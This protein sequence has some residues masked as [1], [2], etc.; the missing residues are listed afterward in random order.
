MT[1]IPLL[2]GEKNLEQW[3]LILR[4][5]LKDYQLCQLS[6][7]N[8]KVRAKN[9]NGRMLGDRIR[10]ILKKTVKRLLDQLLQ[11]QVRTLVDMVIFMARNTGQGTLQKTKLF[12]LMQF[13]LTKVLILMQKLRQRNLNV[14]FVFTDP[15][16]DEIG[17]DLTVGQG[18]K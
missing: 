12:V 17:K 6:Y 13:G 3:K 18:L 1:T 16:V 4:R 10:G 14:K 15:T 5:T 2:L 11:L 9:A 8:F 7:G